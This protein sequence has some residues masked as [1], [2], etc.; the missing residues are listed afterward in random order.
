[1]PISVAGLDVAFDIRLGVGFAI[2]PVEWS[3]P[4]VFDED[5][6]RSPP[7]KNFLSLLYCDRHLGGVVGGSLREYGTG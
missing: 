1:M 6:A 2:V 5:L 3:L 4:T 7:E